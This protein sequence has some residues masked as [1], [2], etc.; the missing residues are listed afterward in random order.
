MRCN[1]ACVYCFAKEKLYSYSTKETAKDISLEDFEKVLRFLEK[2]NQDVLQLAGG[3]PTIHPK[4]KQILLT[5]INKKFRVNLLSNALWDPKLN[6]LFTQIS[7]ITLGFL[8]NIDHPK[9]YNSSEWNTI[10]KNLAFLSNRSNVTLSFNIR[11]K[12]PDYAY[13]FELVS[14]YHF[15][16]LR[17]SFSMPVIFNGRK[18]AYMPIEEY[19]SCA[20]D[21]IDFTRKAEALGAKA[22]MDNAVPICMFTPEELSELV[23]KQVIEPNRNFVCYPAI[24]IGPDLSVWRCFGTSKIF[25]K[26]LTDFRSLAEIYEYYQRVSRLYQFKFFP[27]KECETC[28]HAKEERCQGG[29]IGFAQAKCDEQES[30]VSEPTDNELLEIKPILS[31]KVTLNRYQ[32]PEETLIIHFQGGSEIEIPPSTAELIA[33]LD[34][35]TTL[36]EAIVATMQEKLKTTA[37][38]PFDDIIL[39]VSIQEVLPIIRRL[40]SQEI[41]VPQ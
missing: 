28:N 33:L 22:G 36:K 14:K 6:E 7:P 1:R 34:G 3:E 16:N 35:K 26:K 13:I 32:L 24:D 29:C 18:N 9:T 39:E 20:K 40:L 2:N 31:D 8:L 27:L 19:K 11:E 25:N 23:L 38:D 10:E 37:A 41:L 15:K 4:F 12:N 5:L 17:L 30:R 21:I